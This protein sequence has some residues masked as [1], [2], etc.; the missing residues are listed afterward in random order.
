M[1]HRIRALAEG[2]ASAA[3]L[4]LRELCEGPQPR[5]AGSQGMARAHRWAM[6]WLNRAGF[7]SPRLETVRVPL[8]A[9]GEL[10]VEVLPGGERLQAISLGLSQGTAPEDLVV[11]LRVISSLDELALPERPGVSGLGGAAVLLKGPF[12]AYGE[13][14]QARVYGPSEA[15]RSGASAFLM[16]GMRSRSHPATG[17]VRYAEDA[18]RIPAMALTS[19]DMEALVGQVQAGKAQALRIRSSAQPKGWG[20]CANVVVDWPGPSEEFILLGAHL[21]AWDLGQGAFDNGIGCILSMEALKLVA[22]LGLPLRRG[23]RL[24][25]SARAFHRGGNG[26]ARG[27]SLR[28]PSSRRNPPA[29][30]RRGGGLGPR[31]GNILRLPGAFQHVGW[32]WPRVSPSFGSG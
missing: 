11:P 20:D 12:E 16:P 29:C 30:C 7:P 13:E 21:D 25:L 5:L 24:V 3:H 28:G 22:D 1:A 8:W 18:P 4:A 17:V 31:M 27:V 10:K 26:N 23:I 2:R 6:D 15:A 32:T 14:S 19:Q 9:R